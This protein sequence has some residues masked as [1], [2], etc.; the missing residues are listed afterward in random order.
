MRVADQIQALFDR[1]RTAIFPP[2]GPDRRDSFFAHTVPSSEAP[3]RL[4]VGLAAQGKGPKLVFLRTLQTLLSGAAQHAGLF[5]RDA[6]ASLV[7]HHLQRRANLGYHLW[8]LMILFLW[9]KKWRIRST[10]L[11]SI[12][13]I[14]VEAAN[15]WITQKTGTYT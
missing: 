5:R 6:I 8:G 14:G 2:P 3:A 1:D 7:D 15:P 12:D 10:S 4:Y 13:Q 11:P 9:M